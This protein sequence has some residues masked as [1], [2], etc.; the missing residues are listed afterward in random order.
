MTDES[1]LEA[2]V[3]KDFEHS[4][5]KQ[6]YGFQAAVIRILEDRAQRGLSPWR[7][8]A[9]EFPVEVNGAGTRIDIILKDG[10]G[11]NPLYMLAE[12]KRV[13]PALGRWCFIRT[14][15]HSAQGTR[16]HSFLSEQCGISV[17]SHH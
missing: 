13:D 12:C 1:S 14:Q 6:G 17:P 15:P 5:N 11:G 8:E 9:S 16:G 4:L 3:T 2:E 10:R 7:R